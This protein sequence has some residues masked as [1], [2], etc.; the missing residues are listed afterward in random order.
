M[1]EAAARLHARACV[2]LYVRVCR[3]SIRDN[4]MNTVIKQYYES[5]KDSVKAYYDQNRELIL[6]FKQAQYQANPKAKS[7][8]RDK[9]PKFYEVGV[10][11]MYTV[12]VQ[13]ICPSFVQGG[14]GGGGGGGD[15]VCDTGKVT[16]NIASISI[17]RHYGGG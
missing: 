8:L 2:Y 5:K 11:A 4:D 7:Y 13:L 3:P 10:L 14:G 15:G 17:G 12:W 16:A 1:H 6:V 9:Q